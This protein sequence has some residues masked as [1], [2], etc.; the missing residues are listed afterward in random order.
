ME[1]ENSLVDK[2]MG[3]V[4]NH[5]TMKGLAEELGV[6]ANTLRY[7]LGKARKLDLVKQLLKHNKDILK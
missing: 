4:A 3:L 5:S 7:E 2:A 1:S 6:I